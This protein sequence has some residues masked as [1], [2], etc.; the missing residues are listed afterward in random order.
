MRKNF[1]KKP[2]DNK[3]LLFNFKVNILIIST[4]FFDFTYS[5]L[6]LCIHQ[7]QTYRKRRYL[8]QKNSSKSGMKLRIHTIAS[9]L[10]HC[11]LLLRKRIKTLTKE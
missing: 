11:L 1:D 8:M 4:K 5:S 7:R 3:Y 6:D 10:F 2:K 9:D